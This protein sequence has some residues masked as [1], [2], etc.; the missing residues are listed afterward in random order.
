MTK[1]NHAAP[2]IV[3]QSSRG[4][5]D[6]VVETG[7]GQ[8]PE[9]LEN[10]GLNDEEEQWIATVLTDLEARLPKAREALAKVLANGERNAGSLLAPFSCSPKRKIQFP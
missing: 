9:A 2:P 8:R 1:P 7:M 6:P 10:A 5:C 4:N 3:D